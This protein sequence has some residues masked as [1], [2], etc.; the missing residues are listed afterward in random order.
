MFDRSPAPPAPPPSSDAKALAKAL[1][2]QRKKAEQAQEK[3]AEAVRIAQMAQLALKDKTRLHPAA[4]PSQRAAI[5]SRQS[6]APTIAHDDVMPV[7][8][9]ERGHNLTRPSTP[10]GFL[11]PEVEPAD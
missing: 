2:A 4:L 8:A 7:N 6:L 10:R 3:K 1:E 5:G 9:S 11:D